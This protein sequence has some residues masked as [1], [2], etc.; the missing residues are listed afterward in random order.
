MAEPSHLIGERLIPNFGVFGLVAQL[1]VLQELVGVF[2]EDGYGP[3]R[4]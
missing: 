2:I 1:A 4:Y 3:E